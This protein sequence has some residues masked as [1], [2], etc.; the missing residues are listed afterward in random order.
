MRPHAL[1][2]AV[3]ALGA[4]PAAV[5]ASDYAW[6]VVPGSYDNSMSDAW[7]DPQVVL[8]RPTIDTVDEY[9][10][11]LPVVPVFG[12]WKPWEIY[13]VGEGTSLVVKFD[14]PVMD[15]PLNPCGVDF[16][17]FGNTIQLANMYWTNG[18]PNSVLIQNPAKISAE[19]AIVS[20]SQYQNGPWY[21][22]S[23]GPY[24]DDFAPTLG[25]VYNPVQGNWWGSPTI[26]TYP[27]NPALSPTSFVGLTVA[28]VAIKYGWSAGGTGFDLSDLNPPLPP[29]DP[30]LPWPWFQYVRVEQQGGLTP[31]I[32]AFADI[33]PM[34]FPDLDCDS[35]V[36]HD[37]FLILDQCWTGPNV[38]P[39]ADG[40]ERA[41]FDQD[42]DVDQEDFG[43]WQR[44][45][46]GPGVRADFNCMN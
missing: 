31:E 18:D 11:T 28:Q 10:R 29:P 41:D 19:P 38:G 5:L 2:I 21:T 44:C 23:N 15:D 12:P 39:P 22:F 20:V 37:D 7:D 34:A 1:L 27:L 16:I 36:D 35:D 14:H 24:A 32:D 9:S 33:A 4:L 45:V 17:I 30:P 13:K 8:D 6:E 43:L 46:S 3:V 25:R 26:P 42:G 40:C